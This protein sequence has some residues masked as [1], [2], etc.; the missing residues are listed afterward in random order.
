MTHQAQK[1]A[2]DVCVGLLPVF[3]EKLSQCVDRPSGIE[4]RHA[5]L[6]LLQHYWDRNQRA[7]F[8]LPVARP[9]TQ[10]RRETPNPSDWFAPRLPRHSRG[11]SS[12]I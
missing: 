12:R 2:A 11:M 6:F 10:A 9:F 8:N 4:N 5:G 7:V 3:N 1:A